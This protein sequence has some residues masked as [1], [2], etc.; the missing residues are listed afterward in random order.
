MRISLHR[1]RSPSE[2]M[3]RVPRVSF[4]PPPRRASPE[5][6]VKRTGGGD[7]LRRT[8]TSRFR[9]TAAST[10]APITPVETAAGLTVRVC[11]VVINR[12]FFFFVFFFCSGNYRAFGTNVNKSTF[13]QPM[14][15]ITGTTIQR[16]DSCQCSPSKRKV[17]GH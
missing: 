16:R 13:A 1:R 11:S 12:F 4:F 2:T 5:I 17:R 14:I 3:P 8:A 7:G 15:T 10:R 6:R 9:T